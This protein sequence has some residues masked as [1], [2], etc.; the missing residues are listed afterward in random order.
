MPAVPGFLPSRNAPLFHNSPWPPG[1][2]LAVSIF[3]LPAVNMDVT[4]MGLCG[5]MSFL[6]R[7]I[8][9]SGT[10]Q[11]RG[12]DSTKIPLALAEL[13]VGRL[14][15]SFDGSVTV[16]RWLNL[17]QVPDHDTTFWGPGVFHQTVDA[18]AAIMN[19]VDN[20]ILSPIGVIL[21]GPSW[22]PGDVFNNHVELVYGY[23]K[24]DSQLTLH[25]YDC[26]NQGNDDITISLDVSSTAPAKVI[27]T[28]G[29]PDPD[30]PGQIRGFFCLPYTHADPAPAYIDDAT[31]Y[32]NWWKSQMTP[33]SGDTVSIVAVNTG[34]TTWTTA[35]DYR[36][37]SQAPPDNTIWGTARVDL[38]VAAVDPQDPALFSF[39]IT[40]PTSQGKYA[41]SWQMVRDPD[42]FFGSGIFP[43]DM[44]T[45]A[46]PG[47]RVVP[48]VID[49][50]A[51]GAE[52]AILAAGLKYRVAATGTGGPD[53]GTVFKQA[54]NAGIP[55]HPGAVVTIWLLRGTGPGE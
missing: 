47:M 31:V 41:F 51:Y 11:L 2:S 43:A 12:T 16:A 46:P 4:Q 15:Q 26:N 28:N 32:S 3:G 39:G 49:L 27:S 13:L 1:T 21:T 33:G 5:G 52:Q 34:S 7:D 55:T 14:V 54:P 38:P 45:V 44:V 40:A 9:E 20:G 22:W 48:D 35:K 24:V 10:P 29:T 36:L 50:D 53:T 8:F 23:E 30:R 17:T 42:D 25:V 37:G 6:T 18:C 19:D